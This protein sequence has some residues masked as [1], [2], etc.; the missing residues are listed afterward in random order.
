VIFL[1]KKKRSTNTGDSTRNNHSEQIPKTAKTDSSKGPANNLPYLAI[2]AGLILVIA[3]LLSGG[4]TNQADNPMGPPPPGIS[5]DIQPTPP[6]ISTDIQP[7]L[8]TGNIPEP[9]LKPEFARFFPDNISG[10]RRVQLDTTRM[11]SMNDETEWQFESQ[12]VDKAG[13]LYLSNGTS[14]NFDVEYLVYKMESPEAA[15]QVL[16]YYSSHWNIIPLIK[17]NVTFW[18]WKGYVQQIAEVKP[19]RSN[20]LLIYW[21]ILSDSSFLPIK[22][23]DSNYYIAS[24]SE[25]LYCYH[26]ETVK[27]EYFIMVDVHA[28]QP[29]SNIENFGDQMFTEAAKQ[30]TSLDM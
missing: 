22:G 28:A 15:N 27:D 30:I 10:M 17:G 23:I 16:N 26:G 5:T 12:V 3:Y 29:V 2:I 4:G 9:V 6:G 8:Y 13:V 20:G 19:S 7:E 14:T 1:A 21:D 11:D 25:N 18:L 24:I